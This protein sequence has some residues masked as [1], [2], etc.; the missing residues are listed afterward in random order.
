MFLS[1]SK[2]FPFIST[3]YFYIYNINTVS[4]FPFSCRYIY[5]VSLFISCFLFFFLTLF[6]TLVSPSYGQFPL[7]FFFFLNIFLFFAWFLSP[8]HYQRLAFPGSAQ[9][10]A[11]QLRREV[12]GRLR[13]GAKT[14]RFT[15]FTGRP[16][17]LFSVFYGFCK[18]FCGFCKV[19]CG[20]CKVFCGFCKVFY[21]FCKVFCSFCQVFYGF[22][23]MF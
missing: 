3:I 17:G 2:Y 8:P 5:I 19:F 18:V 1:I 12:L 7:Q 20:F 10:P 23:I 9:R 22:S 13:W 16:D 21:G 6:L 15:R 14:Q 4:F 11:P